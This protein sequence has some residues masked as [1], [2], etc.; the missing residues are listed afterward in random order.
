MTSEPLFLCRVRRINGLWV[1]S[2]TGSGDRPTRREI[3]AARY[4]SHRRR[5]RQHAALTQHLQRAESETRR[6][7]SSSAACDSYHPARGSC[8]RRVET[9]SADVGP[10]ARIAKAPIPPPPNP[11]IR[12]NC[13]KSVD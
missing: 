2:I 4:R 12:R 10:E 1:G 3:A 13:E 11:A 9:Q 5:L 6:A 8:E 7:D